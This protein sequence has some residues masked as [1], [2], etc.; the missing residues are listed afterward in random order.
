MMKNQI[1]N[2]DNQEKIAALFTSTFETSEGHEEGALVGELAS[3]LAFEIDDERVI[4]FASFEKTKMIGAIF[5]TELIYQEATRVYMLAPVAIDPHYQGQGFGQ[6]LINEGLDL[7]RKRS[8]SL[9]VTYGDP[10]FYSKVGFAPVIELI[11]P[12]LKPSMPYGWLGQTLTDE[13]IPKLK[14][15]PICVEEFNDPIYW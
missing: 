13:E 4:C 11:P 12:P 14:S 7:L 3:R 2:R 1:V 8:I 10:A 15:V 6:A 9:V 5:F